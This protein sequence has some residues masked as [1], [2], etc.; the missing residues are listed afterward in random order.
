MALKVIVHD[1]LYQAEEHAKKFFRAKRE[2]EMR[3]PDPAN[4]EL[5]G[6]AG[7][8]T[9]YPIICDDCGETYWASDPY[10]A[11]PRCRKGKDRVGF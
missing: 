1:N 3:H 11:H 4:M 8:T 10:A 2:R 6:I 5:Y 7:H 9:R